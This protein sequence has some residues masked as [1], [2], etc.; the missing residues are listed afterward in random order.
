MAGLRFKCGCDPP[1]TGQ[2]A[3]LTAGTGLLPYIAYSPKYQHFMLFPVPVF[4]KYEI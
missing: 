2:I 1:G 3:G 4:L